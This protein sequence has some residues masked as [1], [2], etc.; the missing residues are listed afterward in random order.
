MERKNDY[1]IFE[2]I[3]QNLTINK[4]MAESMNM[5]GE[6][7]VKKLEDE[8]KSDAL[9]GI[10]ENGDDSFGFAVSAPKD[11]CEPEEDMKDGHMEFAVDG[12]FRDGVDE[13]SGAADANGQLPR[14]AGA[15]MEMA[16][17]VGESMQHGVSMQQRVGYVEA[18]ME[19]MRLEISQIKSRMVDLIDCQNGILEHQVVSREKNV[20]SM[21]EFEKMV[22]EAVKSAAKYGASRKYITRFLVVEK[23]QE[24][25]R[26]FQKK[27][28]VVLKKKLSKNEYVLNDCLYSINYK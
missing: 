13:I 10:G 15:E 27:L 18:Q 1:L 4:E 3:K 22:D 19:K 21:L 24:D 26:Y 25:S 16:D 5:V 8:M 14:V 7:T 2:L 6:H 28:G 17:A 23:L 11:E 12:Q 9:D 20:V